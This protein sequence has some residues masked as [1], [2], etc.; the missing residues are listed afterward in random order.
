MA[1][2]SPPI[3]PCSNGTDYTIHAHDIFSCRF[4]SRTWKTNC[5]GLFCVVG[6]GSITQF[7]K[8][9]SAF[10]DR[11]NQF[12]DNLFVKSFVSSRNSVFLCN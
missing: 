5:Q 12:L 2:R 9:P 4:S 7:L 8:L 6:K 10:Y 11:H 3:V 1:F